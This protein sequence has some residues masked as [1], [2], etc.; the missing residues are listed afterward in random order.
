MYLHCRFSA[1]TCI[2]LGAYFDRLIF[3][4]EF[5]RDG[6]DALKLFVSVW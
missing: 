6:I 1:A 4:H 2:T 3:V 5:L